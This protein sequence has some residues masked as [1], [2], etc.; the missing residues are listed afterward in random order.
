MD[1]CNGLI[2]DVVVNLANPVFIQCL[3]FSADFMKKTPTNGT[4]LIIDETDYIYY[5][6]YWIRYYKPLSDTLSNRKRLIDSLTRRAFHHTEAGISTP[7]KNLDQARAAYESETDPARKRVNAAMLAG[8]LFRRAT[9][10][11]TSIVDLGELGVQVSRDNELMRQCSG[12]FQEALTLGKQVK[13][14]S[15]CEGI[16][17]IWGEPFK[18]FTMPPKDFYESRFIKIAQSKRDIDMIC[19]RM[20]ATFGTNKLFAACEPIIR[21][22][23]EASKQVAET[24]KKDVIIFQIWP[25]FV[26]LAE[27]LDS[28]EPKLPDDADQLLA[29]HTGKGR[30]LL[31]EGKRLL[32]YIANARVPMPLGTKN[33]IEKCE[34]YQPL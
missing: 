31:S 17:E 8:A 26:A 3:V 9:D 28:F 7:G 34:Q 33:Y 16:D 2:Y 1:D 29:M 23:A 13:H 27:A 18:A 5:Y 4:R 14:Y 22:Y 21:D 20:I 30:A 11:F 10:L 24:M 15:G 6:G 32:N 25:N 19:D 12:R